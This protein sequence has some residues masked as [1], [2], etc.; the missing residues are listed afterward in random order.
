MGYG[1]TDNRGAA[2]RTTFSWVDV[3][4]GGTR[5]ERVSDCD[6]CTQ[7]GVAIGFS[8]PFYGRSYST[9]NV[10]SNGTLQFQDAVHYWGPDQL[11]TADF[12]GPVIISFWSDWD[13][14]SSGDV[15]VATVPSWQD[16][17]GPAFVVQW[18][19]VENY[20]CDRGSNA[21]WQTA[22]LADGRIVS[23]YLDTD[24]GDLFCDSGAD[25][26]VGVQ[27][28]S[29]GCHVQYSNRSARVADRTA[30]VW[31][32]TRCG[33]APPE[34]TAP[35]G[36]PT[37]T[38]TAT[39]GG[40]PGLAGTGT[41]GPSTSDPGPLAWAAAVLLVAGSSLSILAVRLRRRRDGFACDP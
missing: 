25:M 32:P 12:A 23:Q 7:V 30:I 41:G 2:P 33:E 28:A 37:P 9:L 21:T 26:T 40:P 22:L 6:D 24:V 38:P 17:S 5:L 20:D 29:S 36:S 16:G 19:N 4:A 13:T 10:N 15:Y 1:W 34:E 27:D 8:F 35:A 39:P 31:T 3:S 18:Q 14:A 11:P